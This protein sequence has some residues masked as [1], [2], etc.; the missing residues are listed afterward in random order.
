M[1]MHTH[2]SLSLWASH[3]EIVIWNMPLVRYV[4]LWFENRAQAFTYSNTKV[5][6][7]TYHWLNPRNDSCLLTWKKRFGFRR[8]RIIF[9]FDILSANFE[10]ENHYASDTMYMCYNLVLHQR[11][12]LVRIPIKRNIYWSEIIMATIIQPTS[13]ANSLNCNN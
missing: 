7:K 5:R 9:W 8:S 2:R 13:M 3:C 1:H 11:H 12:R 6:D 4:I 10:G